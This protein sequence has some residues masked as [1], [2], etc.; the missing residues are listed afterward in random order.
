M[1]ARCFTFSVR[2]SA[3]YTKCDFGD[4]MQISFGKSEHPDIA[5]CDRV[6][7]NEYSVNHTFRSCCTISS[8]ETDP[9]MKKRIMKLHVQ[10][11]VAGI[12]EIDLSRY[13]LQTSWTGLTSAS[14]WFKKDEELLGCLL[15][16]IKCSTKIRRENSV[17]VAQIRSAVQKSSEGFSPLKSSRQYSISSPNTQ[18]SPPLMN[19]GRNSL[20]NNQPLSATL[21][22]PK[23]TSLDLQDAFSS[24]F[25]PSSSSVLKRRWKDNQGKNV[26]THLPQKSETISDSCIFDVHSLHEQDA[27]IPPT[28]FSG[29]SS[30]MAVI[31]P[32]DINFKDV[33]SSSVESKNKPLS[34]LP[35]CSK[36]IVHDATNIVSVAHPN[37]ILP[38]PCHF[39]SDFRNETPRGKNRFLSDGYTE[40]VGTKDRSL[41]LDHCRFPSQS[42]A[43]TGDESS[44]SLP[45]SQ[46]CIAQPKL[47][48]S[49]SF[50]SNDF[51][52]SC[53][54]TFSHTPS[55]SFIYK[56]TETGG[57]QNQISTDTTMFSYNHTLTDSNKNNNTSSSMEGFVSTGNVKAQSAPFTI[58]QQSTAVDESSIL[59]PSISLSIQK[60]DAALQTETPLPNHPPPPY[61]YA[62]PVPLDS[63]QKCFEA[64]WK[65]LEA[66]PP[67]SPPCQISPSPPADLLVNIINYALLGP[68][69]NE[70]TLI[71]TPSPMIS[72]Q[73]TD[74][75][76][77]KTFPS[78]IPVLQEEQSFKTKRHSQ[79]PAQNLNIIVDKIENGT[80]QN[81]EQE[82]KH[83]KIEEREE[84]HQVKTISQNNE[85]N[86]PPV[87]GDE[88]DSIHFRLPVLTPPLPTPSV[89]L[90]A[91][92]FY[93]PD[94]KSNLCFIT[95]PK[96]AASKEDP[97]G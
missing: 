71:R 87:M 88:T 56:S 18:I 27:F 73:E 79:E 41:Q 52:N 62:S 72:A 39:P 31:H 6:S 95:N 90:T 24:F 25:A 91:D 37:I 69:S 74:Q 65:K 10:G 8:D 80:T 43:V 17:S 34:T 85:S 70:Q 13:F 33:L 16:R 4:N 12:V 15:Y 64:D 59:F 23:E 29:Q 66:S 97:R 54:H 89:S 30:S 86:V 92:P 47:S 58:S 11:L 93:I 45:L 68:H 40:H 76:T 36:N 19:G 22:V 1:V 50:S 21:L 75:V 28:S 78:V 3:V 48:S 32:H 94:L 42:V 49:S 84:T 38:R 96:K 46:N 82:R 61:S 9:Y 7:A 60:K 63:P 20:Q 26:T 57:H 44:L 67:V 77:Q 53:Q 51:M 83:D 35:L 5:E 14:L 2:V 55:S 81:R